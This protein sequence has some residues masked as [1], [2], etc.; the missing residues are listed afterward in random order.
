MDITSWDWYIMKNE[1][2]YKISIILPV[3]NVEKYIDDSFTSLL[4]QTFGFSNLEIIFVDD[5]STDRSPEIIDEYAREYENVSSYH[6]EENSG[7]A[8]KPR[9]VGIEK[10]TADYLIFLDSDDLL[11]EDACEVLYNEIEQNNDVD[12]VIGGY[13]N[14][15]PDGRIFTQVPKGFK[16]IYSDGT[17]VNRVPEDTPRISISEAPD[18]HFILFRLPAS[19]S[20]KLFKKDFLI[21]NN[22]CYEEF[23][24]SQ[25]AIFV[26]EVLLSCKKAVILNDYSVY[27]RIVRSEGETKSTSFTVSY[28]FITKLLKAYNII[29]DK[30][31]NGEFRDYIKPIVCAKM[32]SYFFDKLNSH[33]LS[34]QEIDDIIETEGY[35]KF[36][37]RQFFRS[38][39]EFKILFDNIYN[40]ETN[41]NY[42]AFL[43]GTI[44]KNFNYRQDIKR[45]TGAVQDYKIE[46]TEFRNKIN[47]LTKDNKELADK[48]DE[49]ST[50]VELMEKSTSWKITSPMRKA[51]KKLK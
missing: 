46:N 30:C 28:D 44:I 6:L 21:K 36:K 2:N 5:C 7:Y 45:L 29:S 1:N 18:R 23:I 32:V 13:T 20:S 43:K 8:G 33:G 15:Y 48:Y 50:K 27:S 35:N 26:Y 11:S 31:D 9:N 14:I 40:L 17:E 38:N 16:A 47:E 39:H 37:N 12:L 42:A 34:K 19:I 49:A 10:S 24:P 4:N 25:D 41:A 22:I 3:Y 51:G